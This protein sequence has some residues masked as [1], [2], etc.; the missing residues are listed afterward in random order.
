MIDGDDPTDGSDVGVARGPDS[1]VAFPGREAL[2]AI[3]V[4]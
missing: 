1:E 4:Q 2:R 3:V